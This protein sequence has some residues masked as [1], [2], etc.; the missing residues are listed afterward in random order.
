M[1]CPHQ[2]QKPWL[3]TGDAGTI[4]LL[5]KIQAENNKKHWSGKKSII[6]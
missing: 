5:G 1:L 2:N 6:R 3:W 4:H